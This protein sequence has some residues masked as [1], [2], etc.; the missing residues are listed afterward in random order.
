MDDDEETY[1]P[2]CQ[3]TSVRFFLILCMIMGWVTIAVDCNQ[4]FVQAILDKPVCMVTPRGFKNRFGF[5]GCLRL[6]R[7]LCGSKYA[8]R[9]WHLTLRTGLLSLGF[10]ES[11]IN[12]CLLCRK[13]CICVNYVDDCGIGAPNRKIIDK[14]VE[15]LRKLGFDLDVESDFNSY[16]G[17]GIE[18]RPDK[19]RIMT[20]KGLIKKILDAT[21]MSNCN[22]NWVPCTQVALSTDPDGEPF[23]NVKFNYASIVGMLLHLSNNTRPD[24]TYSLSQVARFTHSPKQSHATAIKVIVR[25]LART[26]DKGIIVKHDGTYTLRCWVDADF[27]GLHNREHESNPASAKSRLGHVISFAGFPLVWKSQLISEICLS[28]LHAEYVALSS[29][30]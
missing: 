17:I 24:I 23:D 6:K 14:V 3:W 12:P 16:L 5:D 1:A 7:S 27:A 20:Q 28:T 13:D 11:S 25:Y 4:A 26:P 22:P 30:V 18:E 15:D 21:G 8:P 9:D 10:K 29:A 2:V 19:S